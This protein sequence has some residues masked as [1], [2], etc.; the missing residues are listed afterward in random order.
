MWIE[1][2]KDHFVLGN[3]AE[4]EQYREMLENPVAMHNT[5]AML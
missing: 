4:I 5:Y 2:D 3:K 1:I